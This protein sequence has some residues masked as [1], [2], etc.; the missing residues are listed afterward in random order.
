MSTKHLYHNYK[1]WCPKWAE[2]KIALYL[3]LRQMAEYHFI[4]EDAA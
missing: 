4:S 1:F 3:T 2:S